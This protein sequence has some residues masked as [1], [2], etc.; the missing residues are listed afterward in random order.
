[1]EGLEYELEIKLMVDDRELEYLEYMLSKLED[2]AFSAAEQIALLG[3]Q[4]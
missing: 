2:D 4:T 1:L 3:D